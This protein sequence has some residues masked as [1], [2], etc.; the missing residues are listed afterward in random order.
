[1]DSDERS[2]P[3]TSTS[4]KLLKYQTIC[5]THLLSTH[6]SRFDN[7]HTP[8]HAHIQGYALRLCFHYELLYQYEGIPSIARSMAGQAEA[9]VLISQSHE[10]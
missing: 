2:A 8:P 3:I 7:T 4:N 9:N 1:M 10:L 5:S 6:F